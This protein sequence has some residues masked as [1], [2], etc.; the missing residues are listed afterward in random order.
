[1]SKTILHEKEVSPEII[2]YLKVKGLKPP[3]GGTEQ[4]VQPTKP[5]IQIS[6]EDIQNYINKIKNK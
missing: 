3:A 2:E 4:P 1:M 6:A 5:E